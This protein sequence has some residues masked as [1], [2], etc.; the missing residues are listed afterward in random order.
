VLGTV[1]AVGWMA[2]LRA[3]EME[4]W[5]RWE[6]GGAVLEGDDEAVSWM[7]Q[8]TRVHGQTSAENM[9]GSRE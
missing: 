4:I 2:V 8:C 7:G 1:A 5:D 6:V 9:E 3:A